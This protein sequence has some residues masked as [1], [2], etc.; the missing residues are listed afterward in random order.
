MGGWG[1]QRI[2]KNAKTNLYFDSALVKGVLRPANERISVARLSREN[3]SGVLRITY[4]K[5]LLVQGQGVYGPSSR[6]S[7]LHLTLISL[8]SSPPP[9]HRPIH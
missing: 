5:P 7:H 6:R 2:L 3:H 9:L 4:L 1:E 8:S